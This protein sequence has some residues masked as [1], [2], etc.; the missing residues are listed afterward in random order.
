MV[1]VDT[2]LT[3]LNDHLRSSITIERL[4]SVLADM[5]MELDEAL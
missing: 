3:E 2:T 5:G 1:I 4:E